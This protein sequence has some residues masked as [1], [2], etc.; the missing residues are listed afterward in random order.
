[1]LTINDLLYKLMN[2][3][4][5]YCMREWRIN[6]TKLLACFWRSHWKSK[7]DTSNGS[8]HYARY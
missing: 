5:N 4:M 3:Y 2:A 1:M 7:F 6:N 8:L